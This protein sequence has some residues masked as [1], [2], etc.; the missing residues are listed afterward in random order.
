MRVS[1]QRRGAENAEKAQ[2]RPRGTG[3]ASP[4][5]GRIG[6]L[7]PRLLRAVVAWVFLVVECGAQ[8]LP[9]TVEKPLGA[10]VLRPY[11]SP[12]VPGVRL[13]NSSRLNS[14]LRAGKLYL[15]V[16]DAIALAIENNLG[17]ETDRYGP[18]VAQSALERAQAGGGAGP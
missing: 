14:L 2:R 1:L 16:Q 11:R 10:S 5:F 6:R 4:R 12:A 18:L 3:Q 9:F 17:L 8:T 7:P 13:N 15:T